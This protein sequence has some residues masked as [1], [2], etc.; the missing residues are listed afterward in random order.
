M[1]ST[2]LISVALCT[3]NGARWLPLQLDSVLAQDWPSLEVVAVDDAST[4]GTPALLEAYA[5]RDARVRLHRNAV[6]VGLRRNFEI[7][8]GLCRGELVAPC[9]QDD[10]WRPDKLRLLTAALDGHA[11]AYCDSLLVDEQGHSLGRRL[12]DI[13]RL[14]A[15]DDPAVQIFGNCISGHALLLRRA[16]AERALPFPEGMA[17]DW[18]LAFVAAGEGGIAYCAEPLVQ[19]RQHAATVTDIAGLRA[20]PLA[21]HRPGRALDRFEEAERRLRI[22]AAFRRPGDEFFAAALRLWTAWKEQWL[23]P[24]FALFALRNRRRLF[25][26]RRSERRR[27]VLAALRLFWG[28]RTKRLFRRRAYRRLES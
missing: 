17:H 16:V 25:A 3:Y 27:R 6:N 2:P 1:P 11:A 13:L 21:R 23:S 9:D 18:W 7:A 20:D 28:L 5:A 22:F 19:Y 12:S 14:R 4:D 24:R 15:I 10:V 26:F 8:L